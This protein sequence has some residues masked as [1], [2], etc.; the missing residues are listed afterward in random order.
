M[1]DSILF[2]IQ[3]NHCLPKNISVFLCLLVS[4]LLS[5]WNSNR[6]KKM[7][8]VFPFVFISYDC[9]S[10]QGFGDH[11]FWGWH[12]GFA[13][14]ERWHSMTKRQWW[15]NLLASG[16]PR[17][18]E[19][20]ETEER[21]WNPTTSF[22]D[23]P[24]VNFLSLSYSR[25]HHLPIV[26]LPGNPDS[27]LLLPCTVSLWTLC[28]ENDHL[29]ITFCPGFMV[30]EGLGGGETAAAKQR[31]AVLHLSSQEAEKGST[32]VFL[33]GNTLTGTLTSVTYGSPR[34]FQSQPW[35]QWRLTITFIHQTTA[36]II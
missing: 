31:T 11:L 36:F 9:H 27:P 6:T 29:D 3:N 20:K 16:W 24:Q 5:S 13:Q 17:S 14:L 25:F 4:H 34:W 28:T 23:T 8:K 10:E 12:Y 30:S 2:S 7:L 22:K 19:G 35:W 18:K 32:Q 1:W 21:D 15:N 33:S 26:L